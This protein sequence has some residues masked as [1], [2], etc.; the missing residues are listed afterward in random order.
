V[1][2]ELPAGTVADI[3]SAKTLDDA[4]AAAE[5]AGKGIPPVIAAA[6]LKSQQPL[7]QRAIWHREQHLNERLNFRLTV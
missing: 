2:A 3:S 1:I 6:L 4:F 7:A 5:S